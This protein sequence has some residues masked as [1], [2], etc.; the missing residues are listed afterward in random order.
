MGAAVGRRYGPP[1]V[2]RIEDRPVPRPR[3][4]EILVRV[5]AAAV[6]GRGRPGAPR[7]P[8]LRPGPVD[9]GHVKGTIVVTMA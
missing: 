8:V 3:D 5:R 2:V 4:G 6:G 9:A 7:V 1:D